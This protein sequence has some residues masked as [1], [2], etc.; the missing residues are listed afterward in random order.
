ML[1]LYFDIDEYINPQTTDYN[2]HNFLKNYIINNDIDYNSIGGL[3]ITCKLVRV[4]M[5]K[6]LN[7]NG[8]VFIESL[9]HTVKY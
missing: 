8:I 1:N 5:F 4:K 6:Y 9:R 7:W 2:L 3:T